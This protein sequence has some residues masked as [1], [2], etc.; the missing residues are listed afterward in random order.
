MKSETQFLISLDEVDRVKRIH[1]WRSTVDLA[2][3]TSVSRTT[4]TNA[5]KTRRPT[6]DVLNALAALGARPER[7]LVLDDLTLEGEHHER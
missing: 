7:V 1:G 3:N 2:R 6:P 5:L 4:W